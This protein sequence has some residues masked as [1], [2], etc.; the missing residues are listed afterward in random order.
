MW[1][2][3][4]INLDWTVDNDIEACGAIYFN[5]RFVNATNL[6]PIE[7]NIFSIVNTTSGPDIGL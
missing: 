2:P 5:F 7:P 1:E 4:F 3:M 6:G